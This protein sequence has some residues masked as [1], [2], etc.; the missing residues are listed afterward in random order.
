M[1][2]LCNLGYIDMTYNF[3]AILQVLKSA[4]HINVTT[5]KPRPRPPTRQH[6]ISISKDLA[7]YVKDLDLIHKD[8]STE[9]RHLVLAEK[10]H[11]IL[12]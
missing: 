10:R 1:T 3:R 5:L 2:W 6:Y 7:T 11:L 4:Y 9:R 12:C 8:Y